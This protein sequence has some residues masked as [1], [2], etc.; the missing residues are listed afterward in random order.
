M[1]FFGASLRVRLS[2]AALRSGADALAPASPPFPSFA[3]PA[4]SPHLSCFNR[5]TPAAQALKNGPQLPATA[6][7]QAPGRAPQKAPPGAWLTARSTLR[8]TT[9]P[10]HHLPAGG[11]PP[12]PKSSARAGQSSTPFAHSA[13]LR[14]ARSSLRYAALLT[15]CTCSA[16]LTPALAACPALHHPASSRYCCPCRPPYA[17]ARHCLPHFTPRT[18]AQPPLPTTHCL[19]RPPAGRPALPHTIR[20][21]R[22]VPIGGVPPSPPYHAPPCSALPRAPQPKTAATPS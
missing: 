17:P 14:Y 6:P 10:P 1:Y 18:S 11:R 22:R 8:P 5:P 4:D 12:L 7:R 20:C 3:H 19:G 21:L 13:P 2:R 15:P 9:E 16:P